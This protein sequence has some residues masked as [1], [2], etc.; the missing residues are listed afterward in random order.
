MLAHSTLARLAT[1][2]TST[3]DLPQL[4]RFLHRTLVARNASTLPAARALTR[5]L[6]SAI[7]ARR[8]YATTTAATTPT[9]T[10]KKAV[11]AK[12]AGKA[13]PKKTA[14][15]KTA[16]KPVRKTVA[17]KVKPKAKPKAKKKAAPKKAAPKKRVK[18][19]LT[20]EQK[21]KAKITR[22]RALALKEP[23]G[24]RAV[25]AYNE[26]IAQNLKGVKEATSALTDLAKKFKDL[27]PSEREVSRRIAVNVSRRGS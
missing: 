19:E 2:Q 18:K 15:T 12:A 21:D 26:Y 11:K 3:R 1:A 25:N 17:A 23:A 8:S 20:P 9:A 6:S 4:A 13:A 16:K 24:R 5:A 10:V 7:E 22:L 14:A 27:T